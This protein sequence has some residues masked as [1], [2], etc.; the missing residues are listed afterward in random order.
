MSVSNQRN[1]PDLTLH[2]DNPILQKLHQERVLHEEEVSRLKNELRDARNELF[3]IRQKLMKHL[4]EAHQDDFEIFYN[5]LM[6]L[7]TIELILWEEYNLLK[8]DLITQLR[9]R[10]IDNFTYRKQLKPLGV[11]AT[12]AT[13]EVL[14]FYSKGIREIFGTDSNLFTID[15]LQSLMQ[16]ATT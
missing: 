6:N 12:E 5:R 11:K 8:H 3:A 1:I 2:S 16:N 10:E 13:D 7:K 15:S 4:V 14:D 9:N